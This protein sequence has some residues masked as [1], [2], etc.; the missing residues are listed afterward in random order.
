[1]HQAD[2][3]EQSRGNYINYK[4]R[5]QQKKRC[6]DLAFYKEFSIAADILEADI[7]QFFQYVVALLACFGLGPII[8]PFFFF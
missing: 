4:N 5:V 3:K 8:L 7:L 6:H 2:S 1:M